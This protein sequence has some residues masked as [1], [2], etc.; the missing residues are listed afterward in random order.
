MHSVKGCAER[1]LEVDAVLEQRRAIDDRN[2][3]RLSSQRKGLLKRYVCQN[4]IG[5]HIL[6]QEAIL[7]VTNLAAVAVGIGID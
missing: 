6:E 3:G 4:R 5:R 1:W 2:Q 7:E